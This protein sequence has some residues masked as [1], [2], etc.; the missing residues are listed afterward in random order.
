MS[1]VEEGKNDF[2]VGLKKDSRPSKRAFVDDSEEEAIEGRRKEQALEVQ[3]RLCSRCLLSRMRGANANCAMLVAT[4][5]MTTLEG[6]FSLRI[7]SIN[8]EGEQGRRA[9]GQV[10]P[11]F[12]HATSDHDTYQPAVRRSRYYPCTRRVKR[13]AVAIRPAIQDATSN[14]FHIQSNTSGEVQQLQQ[15]LQWMFSRVVDCCDIYVIPLV[16]SL[17]NTGR[18]LSSV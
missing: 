2:D 6:A 14:G 11:G 3:G 7:R 9:A 1:R 5:P 16:Q 13:F 10:L 17:T 12:W 18:F 4:P 15:N 8:A